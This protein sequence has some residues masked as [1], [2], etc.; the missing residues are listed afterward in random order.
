MCT[1]TPDGCQVR[2]DVVHE[3]LV[4]MGFTGEERSTRRAVVELK[5]LWEA[6]RRRKYRPWVPEPGDVAAVRL[7]R[8][9]SVSAAREF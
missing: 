2:A 5:Q 1:V 7:G 3:R 4:A 8:G 9:P 6:G